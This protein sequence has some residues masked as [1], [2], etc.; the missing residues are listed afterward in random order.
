MDENR[1]SFTFLLKLSC[2][3]N[4]YLFSD[5]HEI[6]NDIHHFGKFLLNFE[7]GRSHIWSLIGPKKIPADILYL[8]CFRTTV[9]YRGNAI[10]VSY[11]KDGKDLL[12]F[13]LPADRYV[14]ITFLFQ[15]R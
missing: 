14:D 11:W 9:K 10:N 8:T 13:C 5:F 12:V 3:C 7:L 6:G 4:C 1:F 15:L 2:I